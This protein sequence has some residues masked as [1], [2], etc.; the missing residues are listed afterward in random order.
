M[1]NSHAKIEG[2]DPAQRLKTGGYIAA[3]SP[4]LKDK[5]HTVSSTELSEA[6]AS[7]AAKLIDKHVPAAKE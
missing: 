4:L 1:A 6:L 3:D 5:D 7:V 2:K